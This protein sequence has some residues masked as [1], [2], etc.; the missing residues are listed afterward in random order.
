MVQRVVLT[1][2]ASK[3][4]T[5]GQLK[6]AIPNIFRRKG[7]FLVEQHAYITACSCPCFGFI[8]ISLLVL[9]VLFSSVFSICH[10]GTKFDNF[11]HVALLHKAVFN[12]CYLIHQSS[13]TSLRNCF[14]CCC[15]FHSIFLVIL[16]ASRYV[17]VCIIPKNVHDKSG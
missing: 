2:S 12:R 15:S 4:P 7:S 16:T 14:F 11:C 6:Q 9:L 17:C 3:P 8:V 10:L 1:G 13:K 5:L